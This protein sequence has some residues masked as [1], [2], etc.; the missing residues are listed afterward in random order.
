MTNMLYFLIFLL[1]GVCAY[2]ASNEK[3][4]YSRHP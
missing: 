1:L 3:S 2:L 4:Y